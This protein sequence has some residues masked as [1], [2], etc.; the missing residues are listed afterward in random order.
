[1]ARLDRLEG[2]KEV[3][4]AAAILGRE[5]SYGLLA[6]AARWDEVR[7]QRDLGRLVQAEF[8]HQRGLPPAAR[9]RFKHALVQEVAYG[10]MPRS[11]RRAL[12]AQVAHVEDFARARFGL[13]HTA[14]DAQRV[15]CGHACA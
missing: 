4:Q 8:L 14:A 2:A 6:A 13:V 15:G 11:R 3:V 10:S 5:F 1:M 7:L 12:H 9:S